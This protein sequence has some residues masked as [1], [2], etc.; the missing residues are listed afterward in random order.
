LLRNF[1]REGERAIARVASTQPASYLKLIAGLVP[2]EHR[3]EQTDLIE[4]MSTEELAQAIQALK[5]TLRQRR[6]GKQC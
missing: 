5:S 1:H 6:Q 4:S 2:R 3:I